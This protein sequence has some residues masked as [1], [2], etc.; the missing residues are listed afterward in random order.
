MHPR[1]VTVSLGAVV[2]LARPLA[3]AAFLRGRPPAD[4]SNAVPASPRDSCVAL[5]SFFFSM[6]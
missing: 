1:I 4:A 2:L 6:W 5:R 3:A